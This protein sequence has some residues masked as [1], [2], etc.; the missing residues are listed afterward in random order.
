MGITLKKQVALDWVETN[1][2][3]LAAISD[4][5]WRLAEVPM[6]EYESA[7]ILEDYLEENG[8]TVDRGV[9]GMPTAFIA[10]YGTGKPIIGLTA[11][12]DALPELSNE[13][14]P[15]R[16]PLV[17][18]GPGH[19][20]G[21]NVFGSACVGAAIAVKEAMDKQGVK[22]TFKLYGTPAEEMDIGKP[23]M[24]R[25]GLYNDLDAVLSWHPGASNTTL[26]A[27]STCAYDSIV[28][29]FHGYST[30]GCTPWNGDDA[31]AA[32]EVMDSIINIIRG[33]VQPGTTINRTVL[34]ATH[35]ASVL[36]ARAEVWYVFRN[37]SREY[38]TQLR[39]RIIDVAKAAAKVMNCTVDVNFIAGVWAMLP[40]KSMG[41]IIY[42]NLVLVG[43]PKFTTDEKEFA[44]KLQAT[45]PRR[46]IPPDGFKVALDETLTPPIMPTMAP[47][48]TTDNAD[49]SWHAPMGELRTTCSPVGTP[50]HSWQKTAAH[51]SSIAHKGLV[52]AAKSLALTTIDLLTKREIL[53]MAQKEFKERKGNIE[54]V[55]AIPPEVEPTLYMHTKY[56]DEYRRALATL[57]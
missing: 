11:E 45:I 51:G 36:S 6:Q 9:A 43:S 37:P 18:G 31:L 19:G 44:K 50:G 46:M 21:H 30:H 38:L 52:V 17:E 24:A 20:C 8:F 54:Y 48:F 35:W 47:T 7:K 27:V 28:F 57:S 2:E 32:A 15:Y 3:Q 55:P 1:T 13:V 41:D 39:E 34:D 29:V 23:F 33:Y 49:V 4:T 56:Q 40:N 22:G 53:K 16:K 10:T 25:A 12:Y 5:I 42:N 26:G 14:V